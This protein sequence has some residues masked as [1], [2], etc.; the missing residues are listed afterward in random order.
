MTLTTTRGDAC[1]VVDTAGFAPV[2]AVAVLCV[3]CRPPLGKPACFRG[4]A[5]HLAQWLLLAA[6][7]HALSTAAVPPL[8]C[9]TL[10]VCVALDP[11][12]IFTATHG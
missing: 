7:T 6:C 1:A 10:C 11:L 12:H 2:A 5:W 9:Q 4:T 8:L 3:S